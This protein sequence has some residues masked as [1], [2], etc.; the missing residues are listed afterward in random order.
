M[1]M[2]SDINTDGGTIRLEEKGISSGTGY[3]TFKMANSSRA[4]KNQ[5]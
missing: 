1:E 3:A 5:Q 4:K 2:A